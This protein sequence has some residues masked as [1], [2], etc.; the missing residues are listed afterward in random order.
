MCSKDRRRKVS[1]EPQVERI[2]HMG[3]YTSLDKMTFAVPSVT[4]KGPGKSRIHPNIK[5]SLYGKENVA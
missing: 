1:K 4:S 5:E 2:P 3:R